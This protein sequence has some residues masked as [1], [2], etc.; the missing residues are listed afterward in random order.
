MRNRGQQLGAI[1]THTTI[2]LTIPS[3]FDDRTIISRTS[4][5][6]TTE[7]ETNDDTTY[8]DFSSM[9]ICKLL[10]STH[11]K[12]RCLHLVHGGLPSSMWHRI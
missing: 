2:T 8:C 6:L 10:F 7:R 3:L 5:T 11:A 12:L 1:H 4:M 9:S